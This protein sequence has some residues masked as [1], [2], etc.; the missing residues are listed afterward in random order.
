VTAHFDHYAPECPCDR[1]PLSQV[2][3][4]QKI[5]CQA[6]VA[7]CEGSNWRKVVRI[8]TREMYERMYRTYSVEDHERFERQLAE[9]RRRARMTAEAR[10]VKNGRRPV[11]A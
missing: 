9:Q 1:C 8:P 7:Y 4:V 6:Y 2:C 11:A 5:L 10:G 3:R